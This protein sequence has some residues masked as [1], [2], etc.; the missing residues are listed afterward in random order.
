VF[1]PDV[2]ARFRRLV[3]RAIV[4]ADQAHAE[5]LARLRGGPES[6]VLLR[7]RHD[8][9]D[10]G[11][12]RPSFSNQ[13]R[14][15]ADA[16]MRGPVLAHLPLALDPGDRDLEAEVI[17]GESIDSQSADSHFMVNRVQY[18]LLLG[19]RA[20]SRLKRLAGYFWRT[21]KTNR[22]G[23]NFAITADTFWK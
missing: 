21:S 2:H 12:R 22:I 16:I 23:L 19:G 10:D 9:S 15:R 13:A 7:R 4:K 14:D 20:C 11:L 17:S 5:R 1:R 6:L 3:E 8:L 18:A